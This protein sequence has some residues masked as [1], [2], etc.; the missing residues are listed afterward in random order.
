MSRKQ[1]KK[2][3]WR[4]DVNPYDIPNDYDPEKH[5]ALQ[6]TI[7]KP[8]SL[9]PKTGVFRIMACHEFAVDAEQ[10][11]VGW[12]ANQLGPGNNITL[13]LAVATGRIDA[14]IELVGE[15]HETF[16]DTLPQES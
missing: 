12:L 14:N 8:G 15:Q 11:C 5:V 10:P 6:R 3:P 1:C 7:A 4:K 9:R 16:E 2:C 13:R